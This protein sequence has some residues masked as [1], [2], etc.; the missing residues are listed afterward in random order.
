M[1]PPNQFIAVAEQ[2]GLIE[3]LGG[4]I[5]REAVRQAAEWHRAGIGGGKLWVA[6][7]LSVEQ[8][9]NPALVAEVELALRD[10]G[11]PAELL[12]LE[13]TE[14]AVM[15]DV[16][17]AT[18]RLDALKQLGV[19]IAVD[20]FG[21]GH[22]SLAYIASLPL[23]LLKIPKTFVE[24]L[25]GPGGNVALVRAIV[26]LARSFGLRTVAE[27]IERREQLDPL[28]A[29]GCDLGQGYLFARPGA[30][31]EIAALAGRP[32]P[33]DPFRVPAPRA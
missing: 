19:R 18:R 4:W 33:A 15:R 8:L 28:V 1:V 23:D 7:N 21:E 25:D 11:L 31:S 17:T 30:P 27:G 13:L 22:S 20:D 12:V 10:H 16:V 2:S 29:L 6:V 24:Q 14:S 26:E 3:L 9:A 5:L 32:V